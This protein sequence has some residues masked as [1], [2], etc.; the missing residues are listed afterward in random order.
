MEEVSVDVLIVGGG[1][2]GLSTFDSILKS[3]EELTV[4]LVAAPEDDPNSSGIMTTQ[5]QQTTT[6]LGAWSET[7][8]SHGY[9]HR[10][11]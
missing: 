6:Q 3:N 10:Y 7:L 8:H 5:Q 4:L 1:I 11:H 9:L 2:T